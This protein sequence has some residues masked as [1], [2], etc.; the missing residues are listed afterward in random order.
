MACP[1]DHALAASV[2]TETGE[3]LV[4]VRDQLFSS[5][6]RTWEVGDTG[7]IE[8]HR[9]ILRRLS[10][11]RPDDAILSEEGRDDLARLS[12]RTGSGS[13]IRW[14]AHESI[15]N[16]AAQTG[17]YIS[18]WLRMVFPPLGLWRFRRS[19]RPSAPTQ[20]HSCQHRTTGSRAWW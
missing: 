14:M 3:L 13:S 18:P 4:E 8:A 1:D 11:A 15:P 6:A 19:V 10:E 2:A 9:H 16:P 5:G 7:D 12:Q 17:R 20:S